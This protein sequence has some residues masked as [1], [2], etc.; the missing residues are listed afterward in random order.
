MA[1]V[2]IVG[3][4]FSAICYLLTPFAFNAKHD[5]SFPLWLGFLIAGVGLISAIIAVSVTRY[6]ESH[7]Y[8]RVFYY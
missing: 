1:V 4:L 2:A 7:N 3:L 6:G 5:I 8:I